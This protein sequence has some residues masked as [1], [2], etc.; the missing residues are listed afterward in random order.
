MQFNAMHPELVD[1]PAAT[2]RRLITDALKTVDE[3][4]GASPYYAG[5]GLAPGQ[6][7]LPY[8]NYHHSHGTY[9]RTLQMGQTMEL[10]PLEIAIATVAAAAHD[11]VQKGGRG[12]MERA[13]AD[14]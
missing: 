13:S 1:G 2:S 7:W 10:S 5:T 8:H 3:H 11:I 6:Q 9:K 12:V 4:Y 14:W